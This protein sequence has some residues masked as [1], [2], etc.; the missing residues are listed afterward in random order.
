MSTHDEHDAHDHA[1]HQSHRDPRD[2]RAAS[3]RGAAGREE[4]DA[5]ETEAGPAITWP[6]AA[7]AALTAAV[8]WFGVAPAPAT[9]PTKPTAATRPQEGVGPATPTTAARPVAAPAV[10]VD[11]LPSWNEGPTKQAI[12]DFVEKVTRKG[13]D[14]FVPVPERVAVFDHD[15]TLVCEKPIVHGM[16]FVDRLRALAERQPEIA[17]EEPYASLL[18]GDIE[19]VRR[20][21][22]KYLTDLI[23]TTLSGVPEEQLEA[24]TRQFLAA[25]KHPVFDVPY[26]DVTYQPMKELMALL[27]SHDFAIWICSG[28]GVHFMRP[29]AEA[30]YGI[31]PERVIASRPATEMREVAAAPEGGD[32]ASP[33]RRLGLVVLPQLEVLNDEERK[34]V[35]IGEQ[36]GRRP[37]VAAGNVGTTGDIEMLRWSQSGSRPSLQ[38]LVLHDDATRE[39]AYGEASNDSLEAAEKYGW[40]VVRMA[41]D[42]NRVFAKPLE[43]KQVSSPNPTPPA[44]S[45]PVAVT[46]ATSSQIAV[47]P[48]AVPV[49]SAGRWEEE[50]AAIERADR[51][52]PPAPGGVV[53]LGSSNVR[54]W[55]TLDDDFTGLNPLR[56]GV[57]GARLSELAPQVS[58][59]AVVSRP[60]AVVVSAGGNDIAAGA[61]P[62]QVRDAFVAVV[63]TLRRELPDVRI[64]FASIGPSTK[65][66]S[67]WEQQQ[68]ANG[69]IRDFIAAQGAE[70]GMTYIDIAPA[71]LTADGTPAVEAFI[72]D[73]LHP[74][75][76]GNAR[77]AAII[78]PRLEALLTG[79]T[80]ETSP[81]QREEAT[82]R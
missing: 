52:N 29:A 81:E 50:I 57:G 7:L 26:A 3:A 8:I 59:L 21:G 16:F 39:M 9:R 13:S 60:A 12:L 28:S 45:G 6:V 55:T 35:S 46:S 73:Q 22:K 66:W 48:A 79:V 71:F 36:I 2:P 82:V 42:W 43:K 69:L 25:A 10:K 63:N 19:F 23:F 62:E 58:R 65:R 24:E 53:F 15:G 38:L 5:I 47:T 14:T 67:Q 30:W 40:N 54:L 72:D 27:R 33:N 1:A 77:R 41:K 4:R 34:P 80:R 76:I 70:S 18:T 37:I 17:H 75:T 78:R 20:L 61:S 49:P 51:E 44:T 68:Q 31:G 64:A 74:S 56:R 32:D 11:P